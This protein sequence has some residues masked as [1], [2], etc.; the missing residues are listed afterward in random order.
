MPKQ[1]VE[2]TPKKA[3][4]FVDTGESFAKS[5]GKD[6]EMLGYSG[7]IIKNHWWWGD[8]IINLRGMKFPKKKVPI[9]MQHN[10]ERKVGFAPKPDISQNNLRFDSITYLDTDDSLKF[11]EQSKEGFP[12]EASISVN[13]V[14]VVRLEKDAKMEIN[15]L[16][17]K[18]PITIFDESTFKECS[19]CVFG[20]DS[21]TKSKAFEDKDCTEFS[22]DV[23][24]APPSEGQL[25]SPTKKGGESV[26]KLDELKEKHPELVTQLQD[27]AKEALKEENENLA[28][29]NNELSSKVDDLATKLESQ[30]TT[31]LQFQ[32]NETIRKA[33]D[34][35]REASDLWDAK[36]TASDLPENMFGK[37]KVMVSHT[38]F[39]KDGIL[40][41]E[42]FGTAIDDEIKD[43][44]S[45]IA[46]N[47]TV[48]GFGTTQRDEN[49]DLSESNEEVALKDDDEWVEEMKTFAGQV[50]AK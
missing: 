48:Q 25:S 41:V 24:E 27:E 50:E 34:M 5:D 31:I 28:G 42:A 33:N 40:D 3:F 29:V 1:I 16:K 47:S 22:I 19:V 20:A 37:V 35:K 18:G 36:L 2:R 7:K 17:V 11:R 43:W 46:S 4:N 12:F 6:F 23:I 45:K 26:M 49:S 8:L 38:N 39:V 14:K 21:N 44:D 9:L 13:D 30:G 32:K 10:I 15:G